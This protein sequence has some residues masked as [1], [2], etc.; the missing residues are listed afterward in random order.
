[1]VPTDTPVSIQAI[2]EHLDDAGRLQPTQTM[3]AAA[4][5][6][7]TQLAGRAESLAA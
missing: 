3:D 6:M 5:T 2:R 1:M 7:L 4:T